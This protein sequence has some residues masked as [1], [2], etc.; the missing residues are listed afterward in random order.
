MDQYFDPDSQRKKLPNIHL[1][2]N[3]DSSHSTS[4]ESCKVRGV[5]LL[6]IDESRFIEFYFEDQFQDMVANEYK[7]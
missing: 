1:S 5:P 6:R 7:A 2:P 4:A 3:Q